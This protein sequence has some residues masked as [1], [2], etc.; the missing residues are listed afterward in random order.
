M[1]RWFI[2]GAILAALGMSIHHASSVSYEHGR[3]VGK[4]EGVR[5]GKAEATRKANLEIA[6]IMDEHR[7]FLE[8]VQEEMTRHAWRPTK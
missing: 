8:Q 7:E 4:A 1:K 5:A 2:S 6:Q 3:L